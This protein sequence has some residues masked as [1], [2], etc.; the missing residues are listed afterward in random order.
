MDQNLNQF[1][2]LIGNFGFP[3]VL[4]AYL[5]LRME[6]KI[7]SLTSAITSLKNSIE[8]RKRSSGDE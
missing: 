6:K 7:E 4:A 5:L 3:L 1:A 8:N 2:T